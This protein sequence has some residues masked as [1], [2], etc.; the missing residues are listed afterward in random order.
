MTQAISQVPIHTRILKPNSCMANTLDLPVFKVA[1]YNLR[2][3]SHNEERHPRLRSVELC[4]EIQQSFADA[5]ALV[6][7]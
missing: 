7:R 4:D 3:A 1:A 6:I 5:D 2:V